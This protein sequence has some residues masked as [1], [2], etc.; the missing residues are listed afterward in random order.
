[1]FYDLDVRIDRQ[2]RGKAIQTLSRLGYDVIAFTTTI[3]DVKKLGPEH[4]PQ[5][6][7]LQE[8][9]KFVRPVSF[10]KTQMVTAASNFIGKHR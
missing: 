5:R 6:R 10:E 1:M 7:T 3:S 4:L 9:D 8:A 2:G